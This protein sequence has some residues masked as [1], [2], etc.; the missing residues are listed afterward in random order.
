MPLITFIGAIWVLHKY[1]MYGRAHE[2][3]DYF[4]MNAI[5]RR[6]FDSGRRFQ[7]M[8]LHVTSLK[9]DD[10]EDVIIELIIIH[11]STLI[12]VMINIHWYFD[13]LV[14]FAEGRKDTILIDW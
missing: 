8:M 10:I 11:Y 12:E 6:K 5:Q 1:Y 7:V 4:Y 14:F 3:T 2:L 13:I 9:E